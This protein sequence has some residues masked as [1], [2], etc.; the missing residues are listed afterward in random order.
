MEPEDCVPEL[1]RTAEGMGLT[2][3]SRFVLDSQCRT[4]V[5]VV[6]ERVRK[7]GNREWVGTATTENLQMGT[8]WPVL[9]MEGPE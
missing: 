8:S 3:S 9:R 4:Q 1:L 5:E 7:N 6:M 2:T